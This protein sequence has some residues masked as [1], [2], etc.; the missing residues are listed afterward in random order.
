[1]DHGLCSGHDGLACWTE[2]EIC[3]LISGIF[4]RTWC[5]DHKVVGKSTM[6]LKRHLKGSHLTIYYMV[7]CLHQVQ[8]LIKCFQMLVFRRALHFLV[9]LKF[10]TEPRHNGMFSQSLYDE[11]WYVAM[12]ISLYPVRDTW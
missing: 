10:G 7:S 12:R 1:M 6:N 8:L 11:R 9:N 3:G 5:C 4:L 2:K